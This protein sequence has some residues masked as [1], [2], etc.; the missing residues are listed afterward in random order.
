MKRKA[1]CCP[2]CKDTVYSRARHD[3]RWCSCGAI[4]LD[5]GF[6]YCKIS[7]DTEKLGEQKPEWVEIEVDA[8]RKELYDDWSCRK[9]KFGLIKARKK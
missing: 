2:L 1:L 5:G 4:A 8:T 7:Y 3:M 9:D 6:D